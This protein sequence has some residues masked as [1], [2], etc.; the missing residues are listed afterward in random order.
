M[1]TV[2][3][4]VWNH[5]GFTPEIIKVFGQRWL[6]AGPASLDSRFL[7]LMD[8]DGQTASRTGGLQRAL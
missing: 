5:C 2:A 3:P 6:N 4:A 1:S 7:L 8:L